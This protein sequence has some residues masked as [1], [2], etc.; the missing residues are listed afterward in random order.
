MRRENTEVKRPT[1]FAT[2]EMWADYA[3]ALENRIKELEAVV[4]PVLRESLIHIA[5]RAY[6]AYEPEKRDEASASATEI[7]DLIAEL[8]GET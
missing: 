2:W 4:L 6:Y 7:A 1:T 3:D 5:L 8:E